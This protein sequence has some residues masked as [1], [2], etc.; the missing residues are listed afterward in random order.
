MLQS[1]ARQRLEAFKDCETAP[2]KIF[3]AEHLRSRLLDL[4]YPIEGTDGASE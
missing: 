4:L 2:Y 1:S 3:E